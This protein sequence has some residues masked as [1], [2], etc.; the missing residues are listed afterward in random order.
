MFFSTLPMYVASC[1]SPRS[2]FA[3]A[4]PG[5]PWCCTRWTTP[6]QLEASAKPPWTRTTVGSGSECPAW[7][8][9]AKGANERAR[10]AVAPTAA[11]GPVKALCAHEFLQTVEAAEGDVRR[12]SPPAR[13]ANAWKVNSAVVKGA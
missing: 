8:A 2:G 9:G 4:T 12:G 7:S 10:A 1:G 13:G 11:A 6:F 5:Y 3:G